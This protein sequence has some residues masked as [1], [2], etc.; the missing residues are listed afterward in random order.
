MTLMIVEFEAL[1]GNQNLYFS[2][3]TQRI[4]HA[5]DSEVNNKL[6]INQL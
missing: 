6:K 4:G 2:G 3:F 5:V 1:L